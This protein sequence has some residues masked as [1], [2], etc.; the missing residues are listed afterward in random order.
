MVGHRYIVKL[1]ISSKRWYPDQGGT[2]KDAHELTCEKRYDMVCPAMGLPACSDMVDTLVVQD[3]GAQ[4]VN[5]G[6][7][8]VWCYVVD[9]VNYEGKVRLLS[10]VPG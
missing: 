4:G 3:Y 7:G 1:R 6:C 2:E 10:G 9:E 8:V 5:D